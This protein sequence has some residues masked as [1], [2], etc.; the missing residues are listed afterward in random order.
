VSLIARYFTENNVTGWVWPVWKDGHLFQDAAATIPAK[1]HLDPVG[2]VL[3]E[4]PL[5]LTAAQ[6]DNTLRPILEI[7]GSGR[8]RL[9][10]TGGK[11]LAVALPVATAP[12]I[13][14]IVSAG[15]GDISAPSGF[16]LS[17][18]SMSTFD[19]APLLSV[20]QYDES[21]VAA[22]DYGQYAADGGVGTVSPGL[23]RNSEAGNPRVAFTQLKSNAMLHLWNETGAT[24]ASN[25]GVVDADEYF[26][27]A[28]IGGYFRPPNLNA[29]Y[30]GYFYGG[31]GWIG[32]DLS[33]EQSSF[34]AFIRSKL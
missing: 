3:S 8:K 25:T 16:P 21:A 18:M 10:T 31:A 26:R 28:C 30:P 5:S 15:Y 9:R 24:T 17:M 23:P 20:Y 11:Y 4:G 33:S 12:V 34:Q 22:S 32:Q 1:N 6:G 2:A 19:S 7:D 14:G 13:A 27:V 29:F